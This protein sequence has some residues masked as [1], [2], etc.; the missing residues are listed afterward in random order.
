[1][2]FNL[3]V[4]GRVFVRVSRNFL[5]VL[6]LIVFSVNGSNAQ[7]KFTRAE[8]SRLDV[9]Q[10]AAFFENEI[11]RAAKAESVDPNILWTIA[12]LETRFRPWLRS[13]KNAQG[14]MQFIPSTA[15]RFGLNDPYDPS[16]S[17]RA[18][19]RYVRFLSNSFGG[20]LDSI[21]A[22][23]NSGEGT[24]AA[25][26]NG[27]SLKNGQK[28]I[29]PSRR[30]TI[31][32]VPPY[33]ETIGYVGRGLKIYRWLILNRRIFPAGFA[34]AKF[35]TDLSLSVARVRLNDYELG[36]IPGFKTVA[37]VSQSRQTQSAKRLAVVSEDAVQ[38]APANTQINKSNE[39][40]YDPRTG[41]RYMLDDGKR[42]KLPE[43]GELVIN[44]KIRPET[45]NTA[46]STFFAAPL[47]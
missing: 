34:S 21:L 30:K 37:T 3:P 40:Y 35:P 13:P 36:R 11:L 16:A 31:G 41:S 39:I 26:M 1:M 10:R 19:A 2:I 9:N 15:A 8:F 18:A 38:E 4:T 43:T 20:R 17:I 22:A 29:N 14:M 32:G 45:T 47:N 33:S 5:P 12:Y 23:Y 27:V 44:D 28:I 46:R 7:L 24:V 42:Q 25:Y 6:F